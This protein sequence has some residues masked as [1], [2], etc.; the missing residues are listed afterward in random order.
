MSKVNISPLLKSQRQKMPPVGLGGWFA[1][2]II[3]LVGTVLFNVIGIFDVI[4]MIDWPHVQLF[5]VMLWLICLLNDIVLSLVILW[6]IHKRNI[7]FRTL[8]LIQTCL[9]LFLFLILLV[10]YLQAVA[11]VYTLLARILWTVYLY[12]SQRVR[13]TFLGIKTIND[14]L[15]KNAQSSSCMTKQ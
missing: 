2:I 13:N 11:P 6:F 9:I 8:Y 15:S 3:G 5:R 14:I 10:C 12:R 7:I 4:P 1:V